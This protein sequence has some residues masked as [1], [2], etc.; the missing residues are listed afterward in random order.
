MA[1]L[2]AMIAIAYGAALGMT[3]G[4]ITGIGLGLIAVLSLVRSSPLI[5]V[6]EDRVRCGRASLARAELMDPRSIDSG[7][8]AVIRRGHDPA[9]GDRVFQIVPAWMGR[10]GVIATLIDAGDPHSAWLIASRRPGD[11]IDALSTRVAN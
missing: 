1:A 2:I 10:S 5:E 4:L 8:I 3:I 11:L 9:V 7:Q 6:F